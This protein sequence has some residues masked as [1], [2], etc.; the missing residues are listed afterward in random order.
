MR[1]YFQTL[2]G[3]FVS[4]SL[5]A[6]TPAALEAYQSG[7]SYHR[8][9]NYEQAAPFFK[10]AIERDPSFLNA[11]RSL[12]D[13]YEQ[14]GQTQNAIEAYEQTLEIEPS[15]KQL[16]YNLALTYVEVEDYDRAT[17]YLKKALEIDP[18]Y[19]KATQQLEEIE[20]YLNRK[21]QT[22]LE[23]ETI[24]VAASEENQHYQEALEAYR[25][26]R[27]QNCLDKLA[28]Y[29]G[30]ITSANFYYLEAIA[31]QELG[32]RALAQKK[33]QEAL[34]LDVE[35][36]N[37]NLNLGRMFY[38]D[39]AYK[40][41]IV[42]LEQAHNLRSKD[43]KILYQLAQAYYYN[44]QY[45]AAIEPLETYVY[46]LNIANNGEAWRLLGNSYSKVG[47]SKK[48]ALAF[49]Q[50]NKYGAKNDDLSQ[51]I[52][53]DVAEKGNK[54]RAL[55]QTGAYKAAIEVLE[56]AI[57]EHPR[58]VGL[59]FNL[60]LNYLKIM[61]IN[62][63]KAQ[64]I[65]TLELDPAH[66]KAYHALG[67]IHY[68]REEFK[69]AGG[70]FRASIEAGKKDAYLYYQMGSCWFK[71]KQFEQ[72]IEVFNQA[73]ALN[74]Q[75]KYFFFSLGA[76]QLA[77]NQQ[78]KAIES[79]KKALAL[80]PQYWEAQYT[81]A[82]AYFKIAK[83]EQCMAEAQKIIDQNP[84]YAKAYLIIGHSYHRMGQYGLASD[85]QKEAQRLDPSLKF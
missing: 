22:I 84:N 7:I 82:V 81:I 66:A 21:N 79:M 24:Q 70:Y 76:A 25:Q 38:N 74:D 61:N 54:A 3:L 14:L 20:Q 37:S 60:G 41:A 63:A 64:F 1:Q 59:H 49:E 28:A 34:S 53:Q 77:L 19:Q 85:Y 48:A 80:D 16:C 40:Q 71:L 44:Q 12:I 47:Q 27:Y 33:Y 29:Q 73:I 43:K 57:K 15:N 9:H 35:H 50:A 83:Y 10:T 8:L 42:H 65:R 56:K 72:A 26:K 45:K 30:T 69:T 68:D 31:H 75:E 58:E 23:G 78:Y 5:Y 46:T 36:F 18:R 17:Q 13:C 52:T 32:A 55:T 51:Q 67:M 4:I 6:Q 11:H 62:K 2:L 39:Q